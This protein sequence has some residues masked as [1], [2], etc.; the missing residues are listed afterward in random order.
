MRIIK[1]IFLTICL[2]LVADSLHAKDWH[3]IIPLHSTRA[4]VE[5]LLG[6]AKDPCKCIYESQEANVQ[7]FYSAG[8]C[9]RGG[10]GGWNVPPNTV[11]RFTVYP[12]TKK[13]LSDL[14]IDERKYKK[15]E[16]PELPGIFYYTDKE[17]GLVI[18]VDRDVVID[19][20]FEPSA[21]DINLHCPNIS[22]NQLRGCNRIGK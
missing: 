2:T 22:P 21:K 20:G 13:R 19:Y 11:I 10:T 6:P 1:E 5:R 8:D 17:E 18:S 12:K 3:G 14:K 4:D 15:T 7:V 9:K 16:D